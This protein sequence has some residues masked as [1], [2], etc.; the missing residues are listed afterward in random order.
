MQLSLLEGE[1][2]I[3]KRTCSRTPCEDEGRDWCDAP[4]YQGTPKIV[5]K[6]TNQKLGER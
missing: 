4:T 1:L 6:A 5:S 3:Q 2:W